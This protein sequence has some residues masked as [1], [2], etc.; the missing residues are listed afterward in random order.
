MLG[1]RNCICG[2][3]IGGHHAQKTTPLF[4]DSH[5]ALLL[6]RLGSVAYAKG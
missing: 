4:A 6:D 5:V 3:G 1:G 2:W